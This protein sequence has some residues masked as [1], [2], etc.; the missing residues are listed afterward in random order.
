MEV[1]LRNAH[2]QKARGEDVGHCDR[3][4]NREIDTHTA[5]RRHRMRGIADT[6]HT[7]PVPGPQPVDAHSQ[8]LDVGPLLQLVGS[9]AQIGCQT[10]DL[11]AKRR[12]T[13]CLDLIKPTLRDCKAALPI[14]PAIE[15]DENSAGDEMAKG[16][17][18]IIGTP[19]QPHPQHI[20]RRA[21]IDDLEAR[22][23]A[24]L[25]AAPV[26]ADDEI[27]AHGEFAIGDHRSQA[28][29]APVVED[30]VANLRLHS[31]LEGGIPPRVFGQKVQKIPL[32]HE[33][34][35]PAMRRQMCKIGHLYKILTDLPA[36]CSCLLMRPLQK[37]LEQPELAHDFEGRRMDRIPP[38]VAQKI[39][40]TR[41][42]TPARANRNP[43][44]MPAG[45]PPAMQQRTETSLRTI[46]SPPR[47]CAF[48]AFSRFAGNPP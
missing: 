34:D 30:Q 47:A 40:R 32:R 19:R 2:T 12:Q 33:G 21:D 37:R 45:P 38:E 7:G 39:S 22:L 10:R 24:H 6:Q 42:E 5:N 27:C 14:I 9:L 23:L 8:Q 41:T 46:G 16:V 43:S 29:D 13:A 18:G 28:G 25:R 31:Q 3:V 44:I 1:V 48:A 20:H 4:L 15:Q 35:E 11:F 36:E 17:S 26:G